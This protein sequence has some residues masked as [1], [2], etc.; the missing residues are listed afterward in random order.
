MLDSKRCVDM[1][2]TLH[3]KPF[4]LFQNI[5]KKLP[6]QKIHE[7]WIFSVYSVK[8]VFL[9]PINMILSF[10]QKSQDNLL[11]KICT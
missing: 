11:P 9:F 8:M 7:N 2:L 3:E 4:L 1:Q 6:F 5:L 10:Y